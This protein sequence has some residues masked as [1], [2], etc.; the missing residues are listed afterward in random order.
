MS[1]LTPFHKAGDLTRPPHDVLAPRLP[2]RVQRAIDREGAWGPVQA[3]RAQAVAFAVES[4]IEA[5]KL[6]TVNAML[7]LDQLHRLESAMTKD[8]PIQAVRYDSFVEEFMLAARQ[9]IRQMP[10]EF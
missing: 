8:D 4:R 5:A 10:K 2:A 1:D 7:G 6:A 9:Q 3:A